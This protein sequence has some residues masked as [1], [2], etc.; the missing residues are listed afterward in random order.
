MTSVESNFL[1]KMSISKYERDKD[2]TE[3]EELKMQ[4]S[5]RKADEAKAPGSSGGLGL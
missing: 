3:W 4:G 5:M 2:P 1:L